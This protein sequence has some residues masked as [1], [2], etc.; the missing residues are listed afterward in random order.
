MRSSKTRGLAAAILAAL[1]LAGCGGG[2]SGST[3][4]SS[5]PATTSTPAATTGTTAPTGAAGAEAV[6]A[7]KSAV[8]AQTVIPAGTK[9]KLDA[10]CEKAA[11][12]N[13][14]AIRQAAESICQEVVKSAAVPAAAKEEALSACKAETEKVP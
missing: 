4:T 5:T 14:T 1:L 7:C 9:A 13:P 8:Q 3:T 10:A 2:S 6:A 12:G 11:S